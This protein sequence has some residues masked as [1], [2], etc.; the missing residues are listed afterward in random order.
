MSTTRIDFAFGAAH[1][2]RT[3]C[4]VVRKHYL[5]GRRLL[6][7]TRDAR[8]LGR[9]D[10]LLWAFDS[11]AFVPHV[12]HDDP[13]ADTTPVVLTGSAPAALLGPDIA[14]P[15]WLLNLDLECPPDAQ[16]FSRILEI[17]SEHDQ[18]KTAARARW[19][20]YQT[21]GFELHAHRLKP[22]A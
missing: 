22:V 8:R 7:Y 2:L 5:A 12:Y 11:V 15:P 21:A 9:F 4:E 17:V 1:R 14:H 19:R 6:V 10:E 18:D 16:A 20:E 3:A 13:A